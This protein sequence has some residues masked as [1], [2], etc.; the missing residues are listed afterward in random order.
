MKQRNLLNSFN[1]A[2]EG[3]IYSVKTQIN[4]KIHLFSAV[5][6]LSLALLAGFSRIE[7]AILVILIGLVVVSELINTAIEMTLDSV[8]TELD[9]TVKIAK[10]IAAAAVL[11]SAS[12]AV[13]IG[14]LLFFNKLNSYTLITLIAIR[15]SPIYITYITLILLF[16]ISVI[17]K[18]FGGYQ[19]N[20]AHG[21]MPSVHSSISFGIAT[22]ITFISQNA[23]IATLAFFMAFLVAQSRMEAGIHSFFEIA[24]GAFLGIAVV[25]LV[26][27]LIG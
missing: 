8:S 1:W 25:T 22:A 19:G 14:Y 6:A 5:I 10:D 18:A 26:F 3:I 24:M 23:F 20:I 16:I 11:V 7:L 27:K 12:I 2:F 4:M 9:P 17:L 13:A 15:K 21:G